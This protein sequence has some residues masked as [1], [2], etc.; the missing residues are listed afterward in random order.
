MSFSTVLATTLSVSPWTTLFSISNELFRRLPPS[1]S[2]LVCSNATKQL[3]T[4]GLNIT[5]NEAYVENLPFE[6]NCFDLVYGRAV[7]HH[8]DN[9]HKFCR[10]MIRV[11]RPSGIFLATRAHVICGKRDL[12]TFLDLHPLHFLYGGKN[13]YLLS[14]YKDEL[15][16]AGLEN[17]AT[18]SPCGSDTNLFP[19]S[20]KELCKKIPCK[21]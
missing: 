5:V 19:G 6:E 21:I 2:S 7:L 14:E 17:R 16:K 10:E 12:Q 11:L 9:V 20:R 3:V 1:S 15:T 13:A 8:A 4:D 18:L